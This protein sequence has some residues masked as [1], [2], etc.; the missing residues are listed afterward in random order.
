MLSLDTYL[1][2]SV[3]DIRVLFIETSWL[4]LLGFLFSVY[5]PG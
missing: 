4:Y 2:A 3:I 1:L 5:F